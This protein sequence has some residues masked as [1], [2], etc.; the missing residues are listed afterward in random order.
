M[1]AQQIREMYRDFFVR[2]D[3]K[4]LPSDSL[5]PKSDPTL[6]FTS[7]GMV[8]FKDYFLG[9]RGDV[10][11]RATTCQKCFRTTDIDSVGFTA[12]HHTF[13]EMLG[14]FS[15][16]DYFKQDAI[17]WAWELVTQ[18]FKVPVD[19]LWISVFRDD[20]EAAAVWEREA[21]VAR[22]RI[23]HFGEDE[24]FWTMGDTGPCGPCS[25]LYVDLGGEF[26]A[27]PT[28]AIEAGSD[29]YIEIYNLVFTQFDRQE[30]GSLQP[31]PRKNVDTGMGLERTAAVLQ[32]VSS[33]YE[34]D[35]F[36]PVIHFMESYCGRKYGESD[37]VTTA[38]R[39]IS[40][41]ARA[42]LFTITDHITPSNEGRGYVLRRIMRRAIRFARKI[43]MEK[44]FFAPAMAIVAESMGRE[45][46][47]VKE[48][49]KF[50]QRIATKEEENFRGTIERG[51][52]MLQG[53]IEEAKAE[54]RKT[55]SGKDVFRLYDTFGFPPEITREILEEEGLGYSAE[56]YE[57]EMQRQRLQSQQAWKGSGEEETLHLEQLEHFEPTAFV[58]YEAK[59]ADASV[60]AMVEAG[61]GQQE[62]GQS[63]IV[64]DRS[65]FYAESGGQVG[66]K[67]RIRSLD[68]DAVFIV[69][70][71]QKTPAGVYLH[72]GRA[73]QGEFH[74]GTRV[75]AE[76]A[77]EKRDPTLKNHT[78]THLLHAALRE[79][80]GTHVKQAGSKV[81]AD[82]LRFDYTHFEAP[83]A[84][85]LAEI[86]E[87]VNQ[88]IGEGH[89]LATET[90]SLEEARKRG[91]MALFGEKYGEEVRLVSV[92]GIS[93]ELCG[94]T[95]CDNTFEV[96]LFRIA[97]ES[98][99]ASGIRRIEAITGK[100]AFD[101][102]LERDRLLAR[103]AAG[104]KVAPE[105]VPERVEKMQEEL[106]SLHKEV[107]ALKKEQIAAHAGDLTS[108][109]RQVGEIPVLAA[110]VE[111]EDV[112]ALRTAMDQIRPQL[113]P[114]VICLAAVCGGKAN[115]L[116]SVDD[117]WTKQAHAGKILKVVTQI[118]GG[119]GGGRADRAQGGG[120]DPEKVAEAME[121]VYELVGNL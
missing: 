34:T 13:F 10:L 82:E 98:S 43:G 103:V 83:S 90:T 77:R 42:A 49:L 26:L 69:E 60:V 71:T 112:D 79:V 15:F 93:M 38:L 4:A 85:Q 84:G 121:K 9:K 11:K 24:N 80:L 54:G 70:D 108:Q 94:G 64:L 29:R 36:L 65:P 12:R 14:N 115:F 91:A 72:L 3:H 40:D 8:Q 35:L 56:E 78:A 57:G 81:A 33:N 96:G 114:A 39:V 63:T 89:P 5:I 51:I 30:D 7:A 74:P 20:E 47:E 58:G 62:T 28:S 22:D 21:G 32:G 111:A 37:E 52:A 110:Q 113:P 67:G 88:W 1:K 107:A 45:Y 101:Y 46:P 27:D 105:A 16:G 44:D 99:I 18:G 25:E 95:H 119:R 66:D 55:I 100:A 75:R 87:K 118:A 6:L 104:L 120:G 2:H 19:R 41:H 61:A 48:S 23:L 59:A 31:L 97:S 109:V 92:P 116:C 17:L 50:A 102:T 53:R 73:E 68:S 76:V 106:R 86:E 117:R